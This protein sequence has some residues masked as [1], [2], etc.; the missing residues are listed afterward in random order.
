MKQSNDSRRRAAAPIRALAVASCLATAAIAAPAWSADKPPTS[1]LRE[2]RWEE[3]VPPDWDPMKRFRAEGLDSMSD[4]G[5]GVLKMR[6]EMRAAFD[7]API[8]PKVD[9][10]SMKL[11]GYLVPLEQSAAGT[12]EFLLVPYFGACIHVPPPPA[13]QIVHV[14]VDPPVTGFRS[15]EAI[16]VGGTL[17]AVRTDSALGISGYEMRASSVDHYVKP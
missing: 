3:L 16:W 12:S 1:A 13:N 2:G 4:N 9:G 7:N 14:I 11:P 6:R 8:N 15:M 17:K 10:M 5:L